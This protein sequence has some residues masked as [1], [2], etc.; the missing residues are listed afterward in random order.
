MHVV[1]MW[2]EKE[3]KDTGESLDTCYARVCDEFLEA[4]DEAMSENAV[5]NGFLV[6]G[7]GRKDLAKT[8]LKDFGL[9]Y[10]DRYVCH[11]D[12]DYIASVAWTK[13][14]LREVLRNREIDLDI[15]E[16]FENIDAGTLQDHSIEA[17]WEL[18]HTLV[19]NLEREKN[20][21]KNV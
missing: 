5:N 20:K 12:D 17:G 9:R 8:I 10:A 18:M 7:P 2:T 19:S 14:D 15:D 16:V 13:Q 11:S 3:A 21:N 4:L 6:P 1:T